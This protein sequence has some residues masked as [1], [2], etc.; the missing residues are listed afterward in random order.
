MTGPNASL[1]GWRPFPERAAWNQP[2]ES[3][4][5]DPRSDAII[6]RIGRSKPLHADFGASWEG[7]PFGIGYVVVPPDQ[8]LVAVHFTEYPRESDRGP[9]PIPADAPIERGSDRH[10]L[11]V[12][13]T[14]QKLY[15]LYHAERGTDEA[16]HPTWRAGSGAIFDAATGHPRPAGWTSADAAGLSIFAG[17]VRYD[18]VV[19]RG[20][21]KHALRFTVERTRRAYVAPASHL[22][23]SDDD[24][25]LPP[26]GMRVR[27]KAGFDISGYPPQARVVL[28]AL[29]RYGMI[30]A[31]NGSDWFISGAPDAR[32]NDDALNTLKRVRGRDFEVVKMGEVQ[33]R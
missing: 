17:L 25:T 20:A 10:V 23:S 22:A 11:V 13:P 6:D 32:W 19:E 5:V 9:Y 8:D 33:T 7:G 27:L 30:V 4:P 15:E 3:A 18:E 2:I 21:I 26:M 28:L 16:G 12:D 14:H 1:G 24:P 31:D 29:K